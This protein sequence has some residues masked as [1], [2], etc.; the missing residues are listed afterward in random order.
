MKKFWRSRILMQNGKSLLLQNGKSIIWKKLSKTFTL[1]HSSIIY[2]FFNR[3]EKVLAI[4]NQNRM[5]KEFKMEKSSWK[6]TFKNSK[7]I[8]FQY[9]L[10]II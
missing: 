6:V 7:F 10:F 1:I 5:K 3:I 2:L 4:K 8:S 9:Y